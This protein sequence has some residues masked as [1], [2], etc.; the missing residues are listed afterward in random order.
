MSRCGGRRRCRCSSFLFKLVLGKWAITNNHHHHDVFQTNKVSAVG[1]GY[2]HMPSW[3]FS[4]FA[5]TY[6]PWLT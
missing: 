6:T 2:G 5:V 1:H 4:T 3:S